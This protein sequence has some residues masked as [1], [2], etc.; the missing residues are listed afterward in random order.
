LAGSPL[1]L[2]LSRKLPEMLQ[3]GLFLA[4]TIAMLATMATR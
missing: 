1:G 4:Y 3:L 2:R